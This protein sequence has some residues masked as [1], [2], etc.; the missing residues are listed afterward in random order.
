ML[1][2]MTPCKIELLRIDETAE[3]AKQL[4]RLLVQATKS[5]Y[6]NLRTDTR[7]FS[8]QTEAEK[9]RKTFTCAMNS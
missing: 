4:N 2:K 7:A 1:L 3:K 5:M 6:K 9:I 8:N